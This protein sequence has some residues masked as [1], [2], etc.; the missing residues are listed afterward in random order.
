MATEKPYVIGLDLGGTN[1]VFG[2]V[3]A[4]GKILEIGKVKTGAYETFDEWLNASIECLKPMIE[5][6]GGI[7]KIKAMGAGAPNGNYYKGTIEFAPNLKWGKGIV[8]FAKAFEEKLGIP[9]KLTND[10]NAAALGEMKYGAARG[11]KNFIVITLGTGVGSG[12]VVN[13]EMV[14]GCD[15]FAGELGHVIVV[16]DGRQCGCGFKGCLEA[17]CSATGV[18]RTA[19]E[20]LAK[21]DEPSLLREKNPEEI[22]SL[23]VAIAAGKGDKIANEIFEFTG[24]ILGKAMADFTKF[25]SPEAYIFF[26]GLT[27]AGDLIMN[28][29]KKAYDENCLPIFRGKAKVLVSELPDSDAAVLGASALGWE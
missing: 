18:A 19:R 29:I 6:V 15:G 9:C 26:G 2:I 10:A 3:D 20:I 12:I 27:K 1:S 23:D 11:M 14:Y 8:E 17:Y 21:S 4:S 16:P 22:E 28:P 5:K 13:G 7:E 24:E 25:S